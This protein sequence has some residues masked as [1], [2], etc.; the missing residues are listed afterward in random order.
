MTTATDDD[1]VTVELRLRRSVVTVVDQLAQASGLS[2]PAYL[3]WMVETLLNHR[4]Y[5]ALFGAISRVPDE[6]GV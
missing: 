5:L 2:R 6:E 1:W 4:T 3:R